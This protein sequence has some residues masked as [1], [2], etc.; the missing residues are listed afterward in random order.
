MPIRNAAVVCRH[1][2]IHDAGPAVPILRKYPYHQVHSIQN[3]VLMP[4][5][6]NSHAHLELPPLLEAIRGRTF[7]NWVLNLIFAKKKLLREHY[8]QAAST[9][10]DTLIKTGT[11]TVGDIC[12]HGVSP[13]LLERSGIRAVVFHEIISMAATVTS[14]KFIVS[15]LN[16]QPY[17]II[18]NGISPHSPYTVSE[19]VLRQLIML[20]KKRTVKLSMHIA[21]S[22]D[23][24][25]LLQGRRSGLQGLYRFAGWD[26]N[27]APR[28]KSSFEYLQRIGFLSPALL[29]VH[30]VHV[31][32]EDILRIKRSKVSVAHCPRS[33]KETRVGRMPLKKFLDA[34][35]PVGLGTDSLASSPS[36]NMWDEMRYAY[37]IH[38]H[39]GITAMDVLTMA[40][41]SEEH[42][43][44]LQS[45]S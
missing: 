6:I 42:T 11:T 20:L 34:D 3:A 26:L 18:Q 22:K 43:S 24:I 41:R 4:G 16:N 27:L 23:E 2:V 17:A 28:G 12:T 9:N 29:A 44:E 37:R 32:D 33:N 5:L 45:L 15:C 8:V 19:S 7:P 25:S 1:G 21:E 31:T 10:I 40:T 36:L 35:I 39:D 13:T 14:S 38:R 30:A